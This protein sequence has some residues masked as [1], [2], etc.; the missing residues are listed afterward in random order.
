M[1]VLFGFS[2]ISCNSS[3]KK[4]ENT[5]SIDLAELLNQLPVQDRVTSQ[6]VTEELVRQA[7]V[8]FEQ[9][10]SYL[11]SENK[12][13]K[14][15]SVYALSLL[16]DYF[17]K[18]PDIKYS[19]DYQK[20]L[21]L[22]ITSDRS[23]SDINF[24]LQQLGLCGGD[25]SLDFL[26]EYLYRDHFKDA[27]IRAMIEINS[28]KAAT[29]LSD[30]LESLPVSC[31]VAAIKS[32]GE[33]K[34][35]DA[36]PIILQ[37]VGSDH[38]MLRKMASY[39]VAN[40]GYLP[41]ES[42]LRNQTEASESEEKNR[43]IDNF[44]LWVINLDD[45]NIKSQQIAEIIYNKNNL[46][47]SNHRLTALDDCIQN[48]CPD[49]YEHLNFLMSENDQKL[50]IASL[51][52]TRVIHDNKMTDW[53][54]GQL[55]Q[56]PI[57]SE[58]V[59]ELGKRG[60]S[61]ALTALYTGLSDTSY[62]IQK[63]T[64]RSIRK[65]G[66][67]DILFKQLSTCENEKL[68]DL[69]VHEMV[70]IKKEQLIPGISGIISGDIN[71]ES[72]RA[73]I[74]IISE[75]KL[76]EHISFVRNSLHDD[77]VKVRIAAISTVKNLEDQQS[78]ET[79]IAGFFKIS[80][81]KEAD[82]TTKSVIHL[83]RSSEERAHHLKNLATN[84]SDSMPSSN[85]NYLAVL[86]G[87]GG[88]QAY[89]M[90]QSEIHNAKIEN[91]SEVLEV[92]YEWPDELALDTLLV[93]ANTSPQLREKI[94]S[95]R[96]SLGILRENALSDQVKM[97]YY[98]RLMTAAPRTE[99]K[100]LV[101]AGVMLV[102]SE[103]ALDF[104]I[105][106]LNDPEL[107]PTTVRMMA[108]ILNDE[109]SAYISSDISQKLLTMQFPQDSI[110]KYFSEQIDPDW[111]QPLEGFVALFNGNDL[112][113]WKGLVADPVQRKNIS[114]NQLDSLQKIANDDMRSH[115]FVDAGILRFDGKGKNLCT[116]KE[117][118]NFELLVDWKIEK[119]GDS[120]IYLRGMPQVQI[121]DQY[122][123]MGGSGGLY[124]NN[125][126]ENRPLEIADREPGEWN[127][128]RI[129]MIGNRVTVYLNRRLVVD[130]V[131]MENYW[132]R[133]KEAYETGSIELQAHNSTLY[134]RN[135]YI[136]E[137]PDN[138]RFDGKLFND[139]DLSGWK[140]INSDKN[141]W[142]VRDG[143]L[144][145]DGS[146]GGWLS[147]DAQYD[148]FELTL[149]FRV[150]PGGNSGVFLRAPHE[151][152]PAYTGMEIQILDDYAEKYAN[153]KPWQYTA[154]LYGVQAAKPGNSYR[155]NQWQKIKI[156]C[157][158]PEIHIELNNK[159][160]IETN[161]IDH[162][163]QTDTHPGLKRRHGFLGLQAHGSK[164]EFKNIQLRELR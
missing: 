17:G 126:G 147:S 30:R 96:A 129:I 40:I 161:I 128:F 62:V 58:I 157:D 124:N 116:I 141:S 92:L 139:Q 105:A 149:E 130:N 142:Q 8:S 117:Y 156:V 19:K 110:K 45:Q 99:E 57:R 90:L 43:A 120:G 72:K 21:Q 153:L 114:Q 134:F 146:G 108:Q 95:I 71:P 155:A 84:N 33:L 127:R 87:V 119:S 164:V 14:R 69:L 107:R 79:L 106:Q 148:D 121:K 28:Q 75:R 5:N 80:N 56:S 91:S 27:A 2:I 49:L 102:Q 86:K 162:M 81:E 152:D 48:N 113:G 137:L 9:I 74:D 138:P 104:V 41:A 22:A 35:Q 83:L 67:F 143:I 103:E 38:Q 54:I 93:M 60:D 132:E 145:T 98:R 78:L 65:L 6:L 97:D 46:Y 118:K 144:S 70:W 24:L 31:Q 59:R 50:A 64:I 25:D 42:A 158:G 3:V 82:Q 154:S 52:M 111:N 77:H 101:L 34:Y 160:V 131:R 100:Q 13:I 36:G 85:K 12:D 73:I 159:T 76:H 89:H 123:E 7:P 53:L 44:V 11:G 4:S 88:L 18:T 133:E 23:P 63:E 32:L 135:I 140:V 151:G 47:L 66:G 15:Q 10:I 122:L 16:T 94:K 115:W 1:I 39:S 51:H 61:R 29:I 163:W 20:A 125:I 26:I 150:S 112:S 136:K 68:C 55:N 37:F 109:E